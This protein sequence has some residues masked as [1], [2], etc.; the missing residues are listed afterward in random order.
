MAQAING[1]AYDITP[2]GSAD[3]EAH[4]TLLERIES[5]LLLMTTALTQSGFSEH[6]ADS[7]NLATRHAIAGL[8]KERGR[9]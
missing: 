6:E 2:R 1:L 8:V 9:R 5:A 7:I 3:G 4:A